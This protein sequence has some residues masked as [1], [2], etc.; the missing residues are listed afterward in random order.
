MAAPRAPR[1]PDAGAAAYW[2]SRLPGHRALLWYDD[3]NVWHERLLLWPLGGHARRRWVIQTPDG[4]MYSEVFRVGDGVARVRALHDDGRRGR[5]QDPVYAFPGPVANDDLRRLIL[6]AQTMAEDEMRAEG[7]E[8]GEA[9]TQFSDWNGRLHP[10]AD[11]GV[12]VA[13]PAGSAWLVSA[14]GSKGSDLFGQTVA[15]GPEDVV[16]GSL[17]IHQLSDGSYVPVELVA[18]DRLDSWRESKGEDARRMSPKDGAD[19][20]L[21]RRAFGA[22]TPPAG[23][24]SA[25]EGDPL[26]EA[27]D[28]LRTCWIDTDE[29]GVRYKEWRRVVQEASQENFHDGPLRGPATCLAVCRTMQQ[30]GG[31]PKLWFLEWAKEVGISRR[32]RAWHEVN[33]LI[34]TLYVAG[35]FDQVN[36]GALVSMEVLTRRLLQYVEAYAHGAENPNWSSAK[37]FAGSASAMDLVPAEMRS[38]A[39]RLAKEEAELEALRLKVKTAVVSG[40]PG[41]HAAAAAAVAGGLPARDSPAGDGGNQGRGRGRGGRGRG[42]RP[43]Q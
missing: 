42:A 13:V 36:M 40:A 37:H 17:G 15:L 41:P 29:Q 6:E 9:P 27:P 22:A 3:D 25:K 4:D 34:E 20:V 14:L 33:A 18:L 10:L 38:Y 24:E 28:D 32:D 7:E 23:R 1:L 2:N 39:S 11:A 5:V 8:P 26:P 43:Q 35:T 19:R 30:H 31:N 12:L 16:R 21:E